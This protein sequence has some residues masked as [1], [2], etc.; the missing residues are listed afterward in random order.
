MRCKYRHE[1]EGEG[2]VRWNDGKAE[3]GQEVTRVPGQQGMPFSFYASCD[4]CYQ[5]FDM[6]YAIA[7]IITDHE[8]L[9]S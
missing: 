7:D 3:R 4:L 8:K 6:N 2:C 9:I 5:F 1:D